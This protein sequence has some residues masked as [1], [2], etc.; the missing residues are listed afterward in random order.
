MTSQMPEEIYLLLK[1]GNEGETIWCDHIPNDEMD[2]VKYIRATPDQVVMRLDEINAVR[3]S[4]LWGKQC[5]EQLGDQIGIAMHT[6]ALSA[7]EKA[8]GEK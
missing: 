2:T 8:V 4:I 3:N 7:I 1:E 5:A 6:Q